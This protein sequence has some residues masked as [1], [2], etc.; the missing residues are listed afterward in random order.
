MRAVYVSKSRT[1]RVTP[2]RPKTNFPLIPKGQ[3]DL[4][5]EEVKDVLRVSAAVGRYD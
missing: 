2:T 4:S 5:S 1:T 3:Y